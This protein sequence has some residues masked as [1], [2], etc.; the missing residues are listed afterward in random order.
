MHLKISKGAALCA[1]L[2]ALF[3]A[4]SASQAQEPA[5]KAE[6]KA[7]APAQESV[8]AQKE[9][10]PE[11]AKEEVKPAE[12]LPKAEPAAT[13]KPAKEEA[14]KKEEAA[15]EPQK[16]APEPAAPPAEAAPKAE[17]KAESPP[18]PPN[19]TGQIGEMAA[20]YEQK[21]AEVRKFTEKSQTR[22]LPFV[23]MEGELETRIQAIRKELESKQQ[24]PQKNKKAIKNLQSDIQRM[25]KE[26]K[27][28]QGETRRQCGL[29]ANQVS[30]MGKWHQQ[31]IKNRFSQIEEGLKE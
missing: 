5:P 24:D 16:K 17:T 1:G 22:I 14:P 4:W 7:E 11:P 18:P 19:C 10:A 9:A 25:N 29:V 30:E 28:A 13:E 8:S 26:L 21:A 27:G 3:L 6:S 15:A 2:T 31:E 23:E 20:L 12:T